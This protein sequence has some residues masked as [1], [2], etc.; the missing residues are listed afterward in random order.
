[1]QTYG[2]SEAFTQGMSKTSHEDELSQDQ[3]NQREGAVELNR[4]TASKAGG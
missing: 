3:D 2:R 4:D 1:M